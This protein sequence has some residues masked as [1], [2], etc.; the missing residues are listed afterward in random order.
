MTTIESKVGFIVLDS[1]GAPL[2]AETRKSSKKDTI[3]VL[4][5]AQRDVT[6]FLTR[7]AAKQAIQRTNDYAYAH[8]LAASWKTDYSIKRVILPAHPSKQE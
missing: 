7:A 8:G 6:V 2:W 4:W 1:T 3:G 5:L